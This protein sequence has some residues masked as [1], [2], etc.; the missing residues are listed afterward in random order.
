M[1]TPSWY[2][3][4]I[5]YLETPGQDSGVIRVVLI[6]AE[7]STP[8]ETGADMMIYQ[9]HFIG[10]IGGGTLEHEVIATARQ[11]MAEDRKAYRHKRQYPLGP[12]LGQ[13]CG[14]F[15]E[16]MFEHI[17]SEDLGHWQSFQNNGAIFHPDNH[18]L[19]PAIAAGQEDG[20]TLYFEADHTPFYLYGAGHVGRAVMA[21]TGG[22]PLSRH[23][24]DTHK[25]RFPDTIDDSITPIIAAHPAQIAAYAP[26]GSI[27]L[28]MSYS[29]EMDLDIC[30]AVLKA[31]NFA[32]LG[33]IGSQTKKARFLKALREAG[34]DKAL[35]SRLIC[36][37]GL[38][39][40][41][42]K[43]PARVALSIAGQLSEWTR[44]P[45]PEQT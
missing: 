16:V 14:G 4:L 2:T 38:P 5:N 37:I 43:D 8:R 45:F 25:D 10:T 13:C 9:H 36:P 1:T 6:R 19:P 40:I 7:G 35:L 44:E 42:G 32:H 12:T 15:V 11:L 3:D 27:H 28:V 24:I 31:N 26:A 23:W 33:L 39:Q 18:T 30:L 34:I 29:H 22:L 20:I 17:T 21:V 41:G